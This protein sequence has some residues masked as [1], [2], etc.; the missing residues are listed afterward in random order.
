MSE[1]ISEINSLQKV[2]DEVK[3][4]INQLVKKFK[5]VNVT[6]FAIRENNLG[7]GDSR[8]VACYLTKEDAEKNTPSNSMTG[9]EPLT[10]SVEKVET[11][12]ISEYFLFEMFKEY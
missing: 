4:K 7:Y 6:V 3:N 1:I 9:W 10:Y 2:S 12:T 11:S 8:I 5:I